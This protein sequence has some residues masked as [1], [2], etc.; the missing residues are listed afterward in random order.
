LN[1]S[2]TTKPDPL[3]IDELAAELRVA[4]ST[5]EKLVADLEIASFKIG[6]VRRIRRE[7]LARFVLLH[8]LKPRRPDWL[9]AKVELEFTTFLRGLIK[10]EIEQAKWVA[11]WALKSA[12]QRKA[13]A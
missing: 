4:K 1:A 5:A 3:T 2:A 9:T 13:A 10:E 8:T 11:D 6:K 12:E 7:D